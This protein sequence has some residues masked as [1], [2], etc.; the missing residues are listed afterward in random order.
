MPS[1]PLSLLEREEIA[2]E[3]T[4]NPACSWAQISRQ[5]QRH[6]TTI[7]REV[8]RHGGRHAYRPAIADRTATAAQPRPR[9]RRLAADGPL[10]DRIIT[11]LT[12]G[13]SPWAIWADL[14]AEGVATPCVETIYLSV[15]DGTLGLRPRD[16]LRT[17][18]PRRRDRNC[19]TPSQKPALPNIRDRPDEVEDRVEV[20]HW[21]LDQIIGARNRSSMIVAVERA[22]RF[23]VL[24]T[25][26]EGYTADQALAGM[27]EIFERIPEHLRLSAT[28]D[29][30]SE[31]ARWPLLVDTYGLDG[32][33]CE[34]H[35]PWQRGQVECHNR[36]L[37]YWWP[38]GVELRDVTPAEAN[39]V[40]GLL[41][42]QRRRALDGQSPAGLYADA[43]VR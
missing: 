21:E 9:P 18:R 17:R 6:A 16:V 15:Y 40:A 29:Q 3:L 7:A 11:E 1:N 37:R 12:A 20:G 14:V 26:P 4:L 30:G 36:Q 10:R 34:P 24:A 41:N 23:C 33:F 25:M 2:R 28:F 38:R 31:W 42:G 8:R 43:C 35:S 22:T 27:V 5:L 13:R 39:R 19:R 32:W